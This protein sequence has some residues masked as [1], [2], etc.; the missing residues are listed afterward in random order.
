MAKAYTAAA[1]ERLA[2]WMMSD[3]PKASVAAANALLDRAWGKPV[4]ALSDPDGNALAVP[5]IN[6]TYG[7]AQPPP[8][9]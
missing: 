1:I 4:Q 3:E 8:A 2:H 5:V 9:P 6:V 7:V